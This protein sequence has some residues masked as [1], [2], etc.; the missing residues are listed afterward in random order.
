MPPHSC[1]LSGLIIVPSPKYATGP[2]ATIPPS[3]WADTVNARLLYPILT[4]QIFLPLFTLRNNSSTIIFA[5]PSVSSSLAAPFAAPEVTTARAISG[6]AASLRQELRL[7]KRRNIDVVELRVGNVDL[8]PGFRNHQ[9]QITGTEILAWN[10]QQRSLYGESYMSSV[11]QR[12]VA[13]AGPA[14]IKGSP[15][16]NLHYAVMDALEPATRNFLGYKRSKKAVMYVG[17]G[18]RSYSL[19]GQWVPSGLVGLMMGYRSGHEVDPDSPS[20]S[21]AGWERVQG[22]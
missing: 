11:E 17:R 13:S 21:E 3:S 5:Y 1:Q 2:V 8:G 19:I 10:D 16:R 22:L 14:T 9:N 12:P 18:A 6:F 15:A 4:V 20:G 7:L